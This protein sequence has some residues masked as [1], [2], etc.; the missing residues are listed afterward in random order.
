MRNNQ[1]NSIGIST[2]ESVPSKKFTAK[3]LRLFAKPYLYLLPTFLLLWIW[4]YYPLFSTFS[5]AF[6]KWGM[7]PGTVPSPVGFENFVRLLTS[8]DFGVSILNTVFYTVGI[9]PF[10]III[11]LILAVATH[12]MEGKMKNVYRTMFFIPLILAPVSDGAIWR[13][14][15][16]PTN[17][18]VNTVLL[19]LGII[20][21]NIAFFSDPLFA[22][23]LILFITGWKMMGFG[24]ILFSAALTG[25]SKDYY[26]AI[27]LD[28]A[29]RFQQFK[30]LTL[31]LLS[32]MILLI[33][34]MS[35]LFSSQWTFAYIDMLTRGGP[36]GT[37]TNIYY[38]MYKYGFANMDV[39]LSAAAALMFF[40]VFGI[41]AFVFNLFSKKYAFY[42]N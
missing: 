2:L 31:P 33:L 20:N 7:V 29:S 9:I 40:V 41:I 35:L 26:E 15:F 5:L 11:P 21:T 16:H 23:W 8:K 19:D 28:G 24:T 14:M 32:P 13:W 39:G 3:K 18:L 17:G 30:D 37:S 27:S 38:E 12:N 1:G 6:Q 36:F 10:S 25:I 42:D 4:M 34:M 22:K